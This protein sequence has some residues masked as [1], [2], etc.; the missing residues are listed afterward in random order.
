M[1]QRNKE[2]SIRLVLG[3]SAGSIFSLLTFNFVKLIMV[4]VVLAV[5]IGWYMMD[6]WL[7]GFKYKAPLGWDVFALAGIVSVVIALATISFHAVRAGMTKAVEGLRR[8]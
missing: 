2:I 1:E 7:T 4:S 6:T 8:E 3:A 5:P